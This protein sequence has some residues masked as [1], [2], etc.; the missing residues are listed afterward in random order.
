MGFKQIYAAP[1][2]TDSPTN[3][4]T[5]AGL[6]LPWAGSLARTPITTSQV[7]YYDDTIYANVQQTNGET[8][9]IRLAEIQLSDLAAMTGNPYDE[10]TFIYEGGFTMPPKPVS[11][12]FVTN[13]VSG[14]P[15]TWNF[16]S[17]DITDIRWDNF[18]TAG[19]SLTLSQVIITATSKAPQMTTLK[20]IAV[21]ELAPDKSN[22][23]AFDAF[24]TAPEV[25]PTA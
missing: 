16:R 3:Y 24:L 23:T 7:L 9:E 2:T 20:P 1:I 15:W 8:L 25:F 18:N 6:P 13:T 22:Q 5:G 21:M 14:Y 19:D 4:A 17:V 11:L 12:R 10:D